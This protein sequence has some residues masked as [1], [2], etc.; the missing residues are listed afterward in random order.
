MKSIDSISAYFNLTESDT[1]PEIKKLEHINQY[2]KEAFLY[3]NDSLVYKGLMRK[4]KILNKLKKSDSA[5]YYSKMLYDYAK[6]NKNLIFQ[7]KA[8]TKLG[9]YHKNKNQLGQ[10][11][12]HHNKAFKISKTSYD[13]IN[14]SKSLLFMANIQKS[15]G[16]HI[17]SKITATDGLRHIENT[18][19]TKRISGLLLNIS[20]AYK[21][22][23]NFDKA[24]EYNTKALSLEKES[25][26]I[27]KIGKSTFLKLKSAKANILALQGKYNESI[28][29][30]SKLLLDSIVINDQKEYARVISNLGYTKWLE[31]PNN[32]SSDSLLQ[33][34]LT[35]RKNQKDTQGLIASNIQLTKYYL[36]TDKEKALQYAEAAYLNAKKRNG[37]TA[38]LEALGFV[39]DLK[40]NTAEEAKM[41]HSVNEEIKSINQNNRNLYADTKYE[42][43]KLEKE[44]AEKEK[45]VLK[46]KNQNIIYVSISIFLL[47]LAGFITYLFNRRNKDLKQKAVKL[48]QQ[49][50]IDKLEASYN[51]RVKFSKKIHDSFAANLYNTMVLVENDTDKSQIL[52]QLDIAYHQSRD[53]SRDN[54]EIDTGENYPNELSQMLRFYP[55]ST[56][57]SYITGLPDIDWSIIPSLD[58]IALYTSLQELM[59]NM[60]KHS[61]ATFVKIAFTKDKHY[62]KVDYY[63]DGVGASKEDIANKN[64][65]KNT[66]S[67]IKAIKGTV[68][69]DS[70]K[71]AGFTAQIQIPN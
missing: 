18:S 1:I 42:N 28:D 12:A 14:A 48:K 27:E 31:N 56:S 57:Q 60:K 9:I 67:R 10:A 62:L 68:I 38:I 47:L 8:L 35:I 37:R 25:L 70:E 20:V 17:G 43:E 3:K 24:L 40:E 33:K 66:E 39:F 44:N 54:S 69:F 49:N 52:D 36:N 34:A 21:E 61:Q 59:I 11:F 26:L 63:D 15:L 51:E 45:Q 7:E 23:K 64:G 2:L 5:I 58:K 71:G 50:K 22:Q 16:D 46:T 65:L 13:S 41:Y 30:L 55:P 19:E 4:T 32:V 29:I 53:F 6:E